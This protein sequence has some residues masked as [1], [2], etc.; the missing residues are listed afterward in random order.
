MSTAPFPLSRLIYSFIYLLF[1]PLL[2]LVLAGDWRWMEGWI[3]SAI[4]VL[5]SCATLLYLYF[6]DPELL[7]E[8]YG[9]PVQKEQKPW[10]KVLLLVFFLEFL[11]WFALMPLDAKRFGWSAT[12]P[13]WPRVAGM[14]LMVV[15]FYVLFSAL[16]ENTF[17]AP[18]V[19]MQKERGQ[20]VIS[21]GPYSIV[22]HPMYTGATLLF[23]G[24]PLLLSSN[25]GMIVGFGLI[26]TIAIRS[27]G[28]EAML[29]EELPGYREYMQIVR[30]RIIPFLF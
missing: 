10:D 11:I 20:H 3:F 30:N 7:K 21:T 26:V 18:V 23:I 29:R 17:A 22:R 1:F 24:G 27:L 19:K 13:L 25:A 9:S 16:K 14:V 15:G 5:G 28:E 2:L 8:R 4:F 12:F 6:T